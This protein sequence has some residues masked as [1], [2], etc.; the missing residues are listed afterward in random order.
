MDELEWHPC[1]ELLEDVLKNPKVQ[2]PQLIR[3]G[4]ELT[5]ANGGRKLSEGQMIVIHS[6]NTF[7]YLLATNEQGTIR[8]IPSQCPFRIKQKLAP[9]KEKNFNSIT[10]LAK[11]EPLP[12]FVEVTDTEEHDRVKK[13]DRLKV[14]IVE[15][16]GS[17]SFQNIIG[18]AYKFTSRPESILHSCCKCHVRTNFFPACT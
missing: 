16:S 8:K 4:E 3:L 9:G 5:P 18:E 12:K 13:G 6:K 1:S 2:L 17:Y 11:S 10:D 7:K 15:K 14:V